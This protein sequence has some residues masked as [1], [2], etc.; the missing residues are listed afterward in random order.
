VC[1]SKRLSTGLL[2]QHK[3][4][5][6]QLLSIAIKLVTSANDRLTLVWAPKMD[7]TRQ[8]AE[9]TTQQQYFEDAFSDDE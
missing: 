9:E 6:H 4:I 5:F 3:F 8:D 2:L 1:L 7:E